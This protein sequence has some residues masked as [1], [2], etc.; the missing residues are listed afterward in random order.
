MEKVEVAE[1]IGDIIAGVIIFFLL[2]V[3]LVDYIYI[4]RDGRNM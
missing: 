1:A 3:G 2:L 4:K